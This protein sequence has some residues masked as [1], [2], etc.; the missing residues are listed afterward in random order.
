MVYWAA[1]RANP[2]NP[3]HYA[4]LLFYDET[5]CKKFE[6]VNNDGIIQQGKKMSLNKDEITCMNC[7]AVFIVDRRDESDDEAQVD[8]CPFCGEDIVREDP[9]MD[10]LDFDEDDGY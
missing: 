2:E 6:N 7:D 3:K 1:E 5:Y 9:E 10:E 4:C 8:F